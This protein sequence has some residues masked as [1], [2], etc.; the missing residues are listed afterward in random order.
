MDTEQ[1]KKYKPD[2]K[3][4]R[5]FSTNNWFV[6]ISMFVLGAALTIAGTTL[7]NGQ[8]QNNFQT[9]SLAI[10]HI[11]ENIPLPSLPSGCEFKN[12]GGNISVDCSNAISGNAF[13]NSLNISLPPIPS[14]AVPLPKLPQQC[15]Y[16]T[17]GAGMSVN[18]PIPS[19]FPQITIPPIPTTMVPFPSLPE[20]CNRE[21]NPDGGIKVNCSTNINIEEK[22]SPSSTEVV[23]PSLPEGCVYKNL[24]GNITV[25]CNTQISIGPIPSIQ[26]PPIN[27]PS[28]NLTMPPLPEFCRYVTVH[29]VQVPVCNPPRLNSFVPS[30]EA[31][32]IPVS[33]NSTSVGQNP[34]APQ[35]L[36]GQLL[37]PFSNIFNFIFGKL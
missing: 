33:A 9:R 25:N 19:G 32:S 15:N 31:S 26:I 30:P 27:Y 14:M 12:A 8:S 29:G 17:S 2:E 16:Q 24:S 34:G 23:M 10:G 20:G 1:D 7:N 13:S 35:G 22:A 5:G 6:G 37:A 36:I 18:C 28:I 21:T 11:S 4:K 3:G